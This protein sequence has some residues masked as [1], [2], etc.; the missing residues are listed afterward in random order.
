MQLISCDIENFGCLSNFHM[1]FTEGVNVICKDNGFGKSTLASFI[2][3]MFYGFDNQGKKDALVN[4]RLKYKPWQG[5]VYGGKLTFKV[6]KKVYIMSRSFGNKEQ[7]DVFYIRDGITNIEVTDFKNNIGEE[8]FKVDSQ[9]FKRTSYICQNDCD[10]SI[11]DGINAKLS[12]LAENVDDVNNYEKVDRQLKDMLNGMTPKRSTGSLYK[13]KNRITELKEQL[14]SIPTVLASISEYEK[15]LADAKEKEVIFDEKINQLQEKAIEISGKLNIQKERNRMYKFTESEEREYSDL[16]DVFAV[17]VPTDEKIDLWEDIAKNKNKLSD[18][19][20]TLALMEENFKLIK[21]RESSDRLSY[22]WAGIS[23][24][25]GVA[26]VV[27]F[28]I[29]TEIGIIAAV[30]ALLFFAFFFLSKKRSAMPIEEPEE[31]VTLRNEV[32]STKAKLSSLSDDE[33]EKSPYAKHMDLGVLKKQAHRYVELSSKRQEYIKLLSE[34]KDDGY[35]E[36]FT[37]VNCEIE[38][39]RRENKLILNNINSYYVTIRDLKD[40]YDELTC[41]EE[42]LSNISEQYDADCEK[43]RL[44]TVTRDLLAEAKISF[45]KKHMNPIKEGFD[46]Y[47]EILAQNGD[48]EH[49]ISA[50]GDISFEKNG[51]PRDRKFMSTG[52]KDL[53]GICMRMALIDAMYKDEKPFVVMDDPFVN[54]DDEKIE[55]GLKLIEDIGN[56]YQVIYFTCHNSRV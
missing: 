50:T 14:R 48:N 31:L 40:K 55:G 12:N 33:Y 53:I 36:E 19:E 15:K 22:V 1:D 45:G 7:E 21:E 5:G 9:S 16:D 4:E 54:L 32:L 3:V 56:E 30:M 49:I 29:R 42:E 11:T 6:G 13:T 17:S 43:F 41:C 44:L 28:F 25:C 38:S 46:K 37:K 47:Y 27:L 39:L 20:N 24:V 18:D 10:Y 26:A 51:I 34:N 23:G 8:L 35:A 52:L 2:K